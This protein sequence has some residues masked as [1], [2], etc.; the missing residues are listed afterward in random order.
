M[1]STDSA[2]ILRRSAQS[3]PAQDFG[4]LALKD[5][6]LSTVGDGSGQGNSLGALLVLADATIAPK[7]SFPMH[8]H[9]NVEIL[10]WVV[11]GVLR[12]QDDR[13]GTSEIPAGTLQMMSARDGILHAEG[14]R[15]DHA[16]RLLQI[17]IRP[18]L[19]GGVPHYATARLPSGGFHLLAGPAAAPLSIRQQARLY[20]SSLSW[21]EA[22][23]RVPDGHAAY[24]VSIGEL[25]WNGQTMGDGDGVHVEAGGILVEGTGQAV[26]I[27]QP[28]NPDAINDLQ[29]EKR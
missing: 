19:M 27:V 5:H 28:Q 14:N 11:S 21:S 29:G 23:L 24:G 2:S 9:K 25:A 10:T 7:S 17:W 22:Y 16:V 20:A 15:R 4:W 18:A 26:V 1:A 12:H 6:F 8:L 3:L 13:G